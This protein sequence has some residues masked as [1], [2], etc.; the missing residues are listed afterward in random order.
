MTQAAVQRAVVGNIFAIGACGLFF[1]AFANYFGRL[2]VTLV[3]QA[4][5]LATTAWSGAATSF[6]SYLAARIMNGLFCSVGQGGAIMWI[7]DLFFFHEHPRA[8][9]TY[10]VK[11][12]LFGGRY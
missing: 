9:S 12:E 3:F 5:F 6:K 2:P 8:I 11:A 1:V 4:V 10:K 7:K